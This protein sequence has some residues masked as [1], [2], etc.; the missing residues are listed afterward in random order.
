MGQL[1]LAFKCFFLL[2][3]KFYSKMFKYKF[4]S[5]YV[6]CL[7]F[8][9]K[10][11]LENNK[12]SVCIVR[13][14]LTVYTVYSMYLIC[15]SVTHYI[16]DDPLLPRHP[17]QDP[18]DGAA[19][20]RQHRPSV[21]FQQSRRALQLHLTSG[22]SQRGIQNCLGRIQVRRSWCQSVQLSQQERR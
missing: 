19:D 15:T 4:V 12:H 10:I 5:I 16:T 18:S 17:H 8:L 7:L 13:F 21:W 20:P 11:N 2:Q 1:I 14:V 6:D 22:G 9:I 3:I